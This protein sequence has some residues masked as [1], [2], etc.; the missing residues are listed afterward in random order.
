MNNI[1]LKAC[2][3]DLKKRHQTANEL[4]NDL[5][6]VS[7]AFKVGEKIRET[8]DARRK[9]ANGF[10]TVNVEEVKRARVAKAPG[11]Q[12]QRPL[13]CFI[14]DDINEMEIFHS[15]FDL[16]LEIVSATRLNE[17]LARL[18]ALKRRP[19]LFLLDLYFPTGRVATD[20]ERETM[21]RLR[22]EADAAR[23]KLSEYLVTIGRRTA[24]L[25]EPR[26]K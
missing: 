1:I 19:N 3:P 23:R 14:D 21:I 7:I 26:R 17:A 15:V 24:P 9:I 18:R 20:S 13:V 2:H 10:A 12:E 4:Y 16:D 22:S 8:E 11:A 6:E 5:R 25:C